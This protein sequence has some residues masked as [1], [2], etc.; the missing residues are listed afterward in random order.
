MPRD[1]HLIVG[2]PGSGK[3]WVADKLQKRFEHVPHDE[4]PARDYAKVLA[5]RAR[6]EGTREILA[7]APFRAAHLQEMLAA[8]HV[9]V[10]TYYLDV[11]SATAREQYESRTGK[12][13]PEQHA[14][15]L[16]RY[17]SRDWDHRGSAEE[18]LE[19]LKGVGGNEDEQ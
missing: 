3:S 11:P 13:F 5:E 10:H 4:H 9:K 19:T 18:L 6:A 14:R 7:E 8:H 15:N 17:A 12:T 16:E 1:V 2:V